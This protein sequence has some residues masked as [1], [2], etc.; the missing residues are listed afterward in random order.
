MKILIIYASK[1][2]VAKKAAEHL[3]H[4][5]TLERAVPISVSIKN[6]KNTKSGKRK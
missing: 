3:S 4:V 1:N 2:G 5:I 6:K